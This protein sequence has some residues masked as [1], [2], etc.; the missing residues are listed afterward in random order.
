M[1]VRRGLSSAGAGIIQEG[2]EPGQGPKG[3]ERCEKEVKGPSE[4]SGDVAF[5]LNLKEVPQ[6]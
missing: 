5:S 2:T 3:E 1:L 4:S 6:V